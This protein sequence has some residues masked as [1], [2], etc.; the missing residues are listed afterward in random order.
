MKTQESI[1]I[2]ILIWAY[3]RQESGF[4]W[5]DLQKEFELTK[6]QEQW[7]QKVF[8]SNMSASENLIDHLSYDQGKDIHKFV[9]TA[10]GTSA[11][12]EYLNL[13][14]A[15]SSGRRAE[16]IS[17]IAITIGVIVGI[18]QIIVQACFR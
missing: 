15:K 8:R 4:T 14:E 6:D 5:G 10:K 7:I 11:A 13:Q 1:Y 12:I 17:W 3:D 18:V 9:I 16:T 2:K